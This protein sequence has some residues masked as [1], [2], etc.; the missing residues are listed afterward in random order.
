VP[1]ETETSAE[2]LWMRGNMKRE[3]GTQLDQQQANHQAV[4]YGNAFFQ[5]G[6]T[7]PRARGGQ[8][9]RHVTLARCCDGVAVAQLL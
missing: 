6:L 3:A 5:R 4:E 7:P 9:C 1:Q 8:A 2:T